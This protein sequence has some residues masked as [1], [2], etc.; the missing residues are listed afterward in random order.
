MSESSRC[1]ECGCELPA[2][3]LSGL[4]PQCLLKVAIDQPSHFGTGTEATGEA[5]AAGFV[6][7]TPEELT[8]LIPQIEILE[9]LGKGGMGA[10]YKGRQRSLDRLVAVK[11]LPPESGS[12]SAFAER[13]AREARALGKLNHPN[14]VAI[15]DSGQANGLYYFV[16]EYVDG[17]NLRHLIAEKS[18]APKAALSIVPQLCDALQFAHD[19]GIVHRDI[20]PENILVDKKGR[21][22]IADFGLAK[23]LGRDPLEGNLTATHQVMGTLKYMAPEQMEGARDIDHRADIYSLGVVFYELLTGQL[24]LGRFPPPSK[25]VVID[26]RLDEIV[27]RALEKEPQ[28]RY[29]HAVDVK[30]EVESVV[31]TPPEPAPR[32]AA[33]GNKSADARPA[34]ENWFFRRIRAFAADLDE[35][36]RRYVRR[37][38]LPL[39]GFVAFVLMAT[40]LAAPSAPYRFRGEMLAICLVWI[41]LAFVAF[42]AVWFVRRAFGV[43]PTSPAGIWSPSQVADHL[44]RSARDLKVTGFLT[45]V[46]WLV[47]VPFFEWIGVFLL[48]AAVAG[49]I[50]FIG[51]RAL[52]R[53]RDPGTLPV[54]LAMVPLSPAVVF[55]LPVALRTLRTLARPEVIDFLEAKVGESESPTASA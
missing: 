34:R 1:P 12:D 10:V 13:F 5:K 3:A 35:A 2:G 6:P 9:L 14:I 40:A 50:L 42:H 4:C 38:G 17:T 11:I 53:N 41:G 18:L 44:R 16:M 32:A 36:E 7:P 33:D 37:V 20:K 30:T 39:A 52:A 51:A 48:W 46:S 21:V 8:K 55:G 49:T 29:Q 24:P 26:V 23:L 43:V 54:F 25:K 27:L 31:R 28:H 22:K 45:F 15:H 19:E 47:L